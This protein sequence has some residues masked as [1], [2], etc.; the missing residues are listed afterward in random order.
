ML[1]GNTV[2]A[3]TGSY[4]TNLQLPTSILFLASHSLGSRGNKNKTQPNALPHLAIPERTQTIK[5]NDTMNAN[6]IPQV[7]AIL[8]Y[9]SNSLRIFFLSDS[10]CSFLSPRKRWRETS[11]PSENHLWPDARAAHSALI[12]V[13]HCVHILHIRTGGVISTLYT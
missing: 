1:N 3:N 8:S 2:K 7:Y 4:L 11:T 13:S 12:V 5:E 10:E 9:F 6:N